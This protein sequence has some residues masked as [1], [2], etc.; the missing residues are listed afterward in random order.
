MAKKLTGKCNQEIFDKGTHIC[1][2]ADMVGVDKLNKW[3]ETI[4]KK[5][6]AE[7]IDW[8]YVGGRACIR[9]IGTGLEKSNVIR[10]MKTNKMG[11]KYVSFP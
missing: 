9:I 1:T 7:K 5:T 10:T 11:L 4:R 2:V 6:G 3:V 8:H